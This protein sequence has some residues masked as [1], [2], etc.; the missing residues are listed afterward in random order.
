MV[1]HHHPSLYTLLH[2][3]HQDQA[4]V[5]TELVQDATG[6]PPAKRVKRSVQ[7]HQHRLQNLCC[8]VRDGRQDDCRHINGAWATAS[9][10]CDQFVSVSAS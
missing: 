2:A 10:C 4:V 6:Q 5:P 9:A 7:T 8:D 3:L 1:G